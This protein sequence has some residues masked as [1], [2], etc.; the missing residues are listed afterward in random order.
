MAEATIVRH[1]QESDLNFAAG[2]TASEGWITQTRTEFEGFLACDPQGCFV[3]EVGGQRVGICVATPYGKAG[4]IGELI[5]AQEWRGRGI[6]RHL[7]ERAIGHLHDRGVERVFLD[8][9]PLAVPLYE[10]LGFRKAARSLRFA[11]SMTGSAH[12]D[13]RPMNAQD[14]PAVLKLDHEA[15]GADRGFFLRRRLSL[16]PELAQV[17]QCH[18]QLVGFILGRRGPDWVAGGPWVL[19]PTVE[20]P[21]HLLE[22]LALAVEG[23]AMEVGVLETN[24]PAIQILASCGLVERRACPWRMVLGAEGHVGTSNQLY[25]IGSAAKG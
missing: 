14:L 15:F 9:V 17:L 11:G 20:H 5:V 18:G 10:R 8:G 25:A 13:V 4:F 16:H 7:M 23:I 19:G 3:A 24:T 1:M 6:G 21:E 12:R 2:C 22:S